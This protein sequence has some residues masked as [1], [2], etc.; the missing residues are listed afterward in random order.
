MNYFFFSGLDIAD[1]FFRFP[2]GPLEQ[3]A[4]RGIVEKTPPKGIWLA[5]IKI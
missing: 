5:N 1:D 3:Y 2:L 4:A